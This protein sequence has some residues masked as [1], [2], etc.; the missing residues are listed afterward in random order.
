MSRTFF[1]SFL[2]SIWLF[3]ISAGQPNELYWSSNEP[4]T[5]DDFEGQKKYRSS[6]VAQTVSLIE[7]SFACKGDH[8][9]FDIKAKF[10][11]NKSWTITDKADVL[12]HER[13]HFDITEVY[14]RKMRKAY[15]ELKYP[16]SYTMEQL[17]SIYDRYFDELKIVQEQYDIETNHGIY[18]MKQE[19]WDQLI[20][21]QL[22]ELEDWK[23]EPL[24]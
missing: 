1:I 23:D 6:F 21:R 5:W 18:Q 3:P 20:A 24:D 8:F 4:I 7:Q 9:E 12:K 22:E 11:K 16:C 17:G 19:E 14:A 10:N 15:T 13:K 2:L